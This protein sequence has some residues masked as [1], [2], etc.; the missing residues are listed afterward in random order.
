MRE[1]EKAEALI[2]GWVVGITRFVC[3]VLQMSFY[4]GP[5]PSGRLSGVPQIRKTKAA[6]RH[7]PPGNATSIG[8]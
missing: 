8:P 6:G 4:F 5:L 7:R 2:P 3:L 1:G